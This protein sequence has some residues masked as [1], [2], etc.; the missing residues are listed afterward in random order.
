MEKRIQAH[1][2]QTLV[3]YKNEVRTIIMND[4]LSKKDKLTQVFNIQHEEFCLNDFMK[5]KRARNVIPDEERCCAF[6]ADKMRCTRKRKDGNEVCGT[7]MKGVSNG[8]INESTPAVNMKTV[9]IWTQDIGG[10]IYYIDA[11]NNVYCSNDIMKSSTSPKV[12]GSCTNDDGVF[13]CSLN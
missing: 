12:I 5:K 3:A 8:M 4:V 1:V 11:N 6:R 2:E 13:T 7:H 9:D 10:I